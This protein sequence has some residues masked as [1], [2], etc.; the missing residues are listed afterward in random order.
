[1]RPY[2]VYIL[3]CGDGSLYTGITTDLEARLK[4]HRKGKGARYTRGRLPVEPVY[5]ETVENR[6]A[7]LKR[8]LEIKRMS[9]RQKLELIREQGGSFQ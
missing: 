1:M 7:A 6:S 9:R 8:E 2:T 5:A 3:K 4:S